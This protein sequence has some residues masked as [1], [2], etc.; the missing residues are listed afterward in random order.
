MKQAGRQ[1]RFAGLG[2]L[3]G[4]PRALP[5]RISAA[6]QTLVVDWSSESDGRFGAHLARLIKRL[7]VAFQKA[8]AKRGRQGP[9][10]ALPVALLR[11]ITPPVL[12]Q[13]CGQDEDE[14][15]DEDA[16]EDASRVGG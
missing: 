2:G 6:A 10:C 7:L 5:R 4:R 1:A 13:R 8:I 3:H 12:E 11:M 9:R 15:E 14:D 16:D